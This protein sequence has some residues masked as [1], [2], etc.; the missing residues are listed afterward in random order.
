MNAVEKILG[1]P[2]GTLVRC[3]PDAVMVNDGAGHKAVDLLNDYNADPAAPLKDKVTVVLDHDIPAGSFESAFIQKK[4][5]DFSRSFHL[6]FVQSAGIGYEWM[7]AK[8]V[9][10][11]TL[12]ISCGTHN[13]IV[14]AKGALGLGISPQAMAKLLACGFIEMTVPQTVRIVLKG[15]FG[16]GAGSWDFAFGRW[17][18]RSLGDKNIRGRV[19]E[20]VDLTKKGLGE[21]DRKVMCMGAV[22]QGAL[23]ALFTEGFT[24]SSTVFDLEKVSTVAL[25]PGSLEN[26]CLLASNGSAPEHGGHDLAPD[27]HASAHSAWNIGAGA[28]WEQ[29]CFGVKVDA[30]FIG[31]CAGGRIEALRT[32]AKILRNRRIHRE[33]RLLV[34]FVDNETY[35]K[36]MDEGL[37]DI[38][39]DC[40]AQVTNPGCASCRSSSIGVVGDGEVLLSTGCYND[41]GCAGTKDSY[42]YLASA[43]NVARA[44]LTGVF[45]ERHGKQMKPHKGIT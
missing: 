26:V 9:F 45:C 30:C 37:I 14:G 29:A 39:L 22:I 32:A 31:G 5:I 23:S 35:L 33:L 40:G 2:A 6:D 34:G 12:F 18:L 36:A 13:A 27:L 11:E 8:K 7:Y 10:K 41:P 21:N 1:A 19:V 17:L 20:F 25:C 16:C 42:V 28:G 43:V 3:I 24:E 15:E 4:L 44:A 38:F